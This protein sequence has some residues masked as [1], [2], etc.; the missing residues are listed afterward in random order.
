MKTLY[1]KITDFTLIALIFLSLFKII[2][3]GKDKYLVKFNY[4]NL[5][6]L[7]NSSQFATQ[8]ENRKNIIQ[9]EDLY[10]YVGYKY[11]TSGEID[12]INIEHPPLGKYFIGLSTL[13]FKN[14]N[15][16]QIIWGLIFLALLFLLAQKTLKYKTLSLLVIF[17][18][19]QERLFT[20]QVTTSLLDIV[21]GVFLLVF[22]LLSL[23]KKS[24]NKV[25][26][27]QGISLGT[28]ASIKYPTIAIVVLITWILYKV[29]K[30]T[31]FKI[32]KKEFF[33]LSISAAIVFLLTYLPFYFK[34]PSPLSFLK[35]QEK[36]LRI[37]LSH[38]P[39]Y[40]KLQVFNVLLFDR[41][42]TWW[43]EKSFIKTGFWNIGWP[44][45]ILSF[46]ASLTKIKQNLLIKLW[47]LLYLLFLSLRLFFPR[48]LFLLL[49]FLYLN[50]CYNFQR[51]YQSLVL[52][53][54]L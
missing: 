35:L 22:L 20:E 4:D 43:G 50:L 31:S 7:Y 42:L 10:A 2:N 1:K 18:L 23:T 26:L 49:P 44:I 15:I 29:I 21:Q 32:I 48:Y 52:N 12:K 40:P 39:E 37:H 17:F 25:L 16:G 14:Q 5:S 46:F 28:I 27:A 13:I 19:T 30:K 54:K 33:Y 8:P 34:N 53:K 51:L 6:K 11:L 3:N 38:V 36:A 9:D 45:L 47:A 41:W 24:T